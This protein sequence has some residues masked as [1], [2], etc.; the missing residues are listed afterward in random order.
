MRGAR[1]AVFFRSPITMYEALPSN[2]PHR[3]I[4]QE[5]GARPSPKPHISV[6][7]N[8]TVRRERPENDKLGPNSRD[9]CSVDRSFLAVLLMDRCEPLI[10]KNKKNLSLLRKTKAP[11]TKRSPSL[12]CRL[13]GDRPP[14]PDSKQGR[15]LWASAEQRVQTIAKGLSR[16]G[17]FIS[18]RLH[19]LRGPIPGDA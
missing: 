11:G 2:L 8:K 19:G 18:A 1:C 13:H 15:G 17:V 12:V 10:K 7:Q 16:N 6:K 4:E 9:A 5:R 3:A 14:H